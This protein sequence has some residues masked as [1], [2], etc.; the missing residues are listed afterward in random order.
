MMRRKSNISILSNQRGQ[1]L[2]LAL[3]VMFLLVVL[4]AIFIVVVS[5]NL[6][7]TSRST[8]AN[9]ALYLAEAGIRYAD[10]MLTQS[11][12]GADW[13]SVPDN[14]GALPSGRDQGILQF[15]P[16]TSEFG[17]EWLSRRHPDFK[18]VRPYS[19]TE[20]GWRGPT[21][22]YTT[23]DHGNGRF[24]IRIT[25]EPK[26]VFPNNANSPYDPLSKYIKIESIG[27]V[28]SL[29]GLYYCSQ[30]PINNRYESSRPGYCPNHPDTRLD[31]EPTVAS[32]LRTGLRT[33]RTAFKPIG[34]TDYAR[35]ITNKDRR[36]VQA[37]LGCPGFA[38]Q[39]GYVN[40]AEVRGA[41]VRVNSDLKWYGD[42]VSI[43]LSG[44]TY[45]GG[46][47]VPTDAVEV[48]GD[49]EHDAS[50]GNP[51][52][53]MISRII[54]GTVADPEPVNPSRS[55]AFTTWGGFYRD[56][57]DA[58]DR[59]GSHTRSVKRIEPPDIDLIGRY[60]SLTADTGDWYT[61]SIT[62]QRYRK[63]QIG[64][65][66]GIYISN[67]TD[68]QRESEGIFGGYTPR[69][70]WTQPN[71]LASSYW[72]GSYYTPPGVIITL[73]P[74]DTN[75][76]GQPDI[77]I[78]RTDIHQRWNE[79]YVWRDP[80]GNYRPDW[81]QTITVPYPTAFRKVRA[82][83]APDSD[84][85]TVL[86]PG[87]G[88]IFAEGNVRI[89]GMLPPTGTDT[90]TGAP[91]QYNL[92][93]VSGGTIYIEGSIL[94]NRSID[95]SNNEIPDHSGSVALL[96]KEYV[97]I[98]TTQFLSKLSSGAPLPQ[99]SDA[100][101]GEPPYHL[102]IG[103]APGATFRSTFTFGPWDS[104]DN[105]GAWSG[106]HYAFVRH[107]GLFSPA[108]INMFINPGFPTA[109][110]AGAFLFGS[111]P[112]ILPTTYGVGDPLS[113]SYP[114]VGLTTSFEH[115][116]W[117]LNGSGVALMTDSGYPNYL[118]I[119]LA[120]T[121]VGRPDDSRQVTTR[122]DYLLSGLAIQPMNVR[123]EAI[124]YAQNRSFFVI[125]GRWF[126]PDSSDTRASFANTGRRPWG[127]HP[128]F[129]FFG[130]PL[131]TRIV[132]DG[133]VSENLS[134]SV[135]DVTAWMDKWGY[136]PPDYGGS[137]E[138]TVHNGR[139]LT[140]LYDPKVGWPVGD[141]NVPLRRDIYGRGLPIAPCL[142]VSRTLIYHGE[143]L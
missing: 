84:A 79:R 2:L 122:G 29:Q 99:G 92:T 30:C 83:G 94:K 119:G 137:G 38:T 139:G 14:Q 50:V 128:M 87:N 19:D 46:T 80:Y 13:R 56:G 124:I 111:M 106:N 53:V 125:P 103:T 129:P 12:L 41:P 120:Q 102:I 61:D 44:Y 86:M 57:R 89:K 71:N 132:I 15:V 75:G 20:D 109:D 32:G 74:Y 114:G 58:P 127:T 140:F 101:N 136:T 43:Y 135:A 33:E 60:R 59:H 22:G 90:V 76:D 96:A 35:F 64:W 97:C 105:P 39:Y 115:K 126:N 143:P 67:S 49:I 10:K 100:M 18:W 52:Q 66:R 91:I 23:V 11:E 123:I 142:P 37:V 81:G 138:Q 4:G 27:R 1:T 3:V 55:P 69:A 51:V 16:D 70:D 47:T 141:N 78:T 34:I 77:T 9:E 93:V 108:Y 54:N 42:P 31:L 73:N 26:R 45:G 17:W 62:N 65:G 113:G 121:Y 110:H 63:G 68:I 5:R 21:G 117:R 8:E 48:T 95:G 98:N 131:D 118:E 6:T 36:S 7:A 104:L 72:Q 107:A 134:A 133:A 28:G 88:V 85:A 25:Y 40:G 116:T 112:P 130:E 24:L 82:E